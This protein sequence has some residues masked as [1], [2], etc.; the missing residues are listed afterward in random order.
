MK[1]KKV[2]FV[3]DCGLSQ[4]VWKNSFVRLDVK[5]I[6]VLKSPF[7]SLVVVGFRLPTHLGVRLGGGWPS[8]LRRWFKAPFS[9]EAW[10]QVPLRSFFLLQK[11]WVISFPPLLL[12]HNFI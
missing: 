3:Q 5:R 1:T 8:G 10:V 12:F 2:L 4:H 11:F 7:G 6:H 9:S